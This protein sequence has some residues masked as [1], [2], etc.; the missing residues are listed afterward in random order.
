M[1]K[2]MKK[3]MA[4]LIG[5]ALVGAMAA[6]SPAAAG[7]KGEPAESG[8]V[9]R[10]EPAIG[11]HLVGPVTA[12]VNGDDR[13]LL[14]VFGWE[15]AIQ[16]CTGGPPVFNGV[17]QVVETM[18]GNFTEVVHNGDIPVL[19]F[20]VTD[21][22][23]ELEFIDSCATGEL[24]PLAT[25]TAKQRPIITGNETGLTVKIKSQG[26]VTD[27]FGRE[28]KLQAFLKENIVFA[29]F[30]SDVQSEWIKLTLR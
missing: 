3:L 12:D 13:R 14:A 10:I 30:Q 11:G 20:D 21:V 19:V 1:E 22:D 9:S 2:Q 28:W 24:E 26:I 16:F 17:I 29:P 8:V 6:S 25:G 18:S 7:K 5:L 27:S 23:S 4:A 15:S